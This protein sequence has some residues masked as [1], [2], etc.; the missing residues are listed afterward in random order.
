MR[1]WQHELRLKEDQPDRSMKQSGLVLQDT[2]YKG[3]SLCT[4]FR[5]GSYNPVPLMNTGQQLLINWEIR[6]LI[7]AKMTISPI[8]WIISTDRPK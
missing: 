1:Q 6:P 8:P 4:F 2:L 5:T 7:S 3:S